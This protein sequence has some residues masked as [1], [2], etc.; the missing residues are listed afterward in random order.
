MHFILLFYFISL[1]P[2]LWH[3]EVPRLGIKSKLQLPAYSI[4]TATPDL[5]CIFNLHHS[6]Q[7]CQILNSPVKSRDWTHVLT[8][9]SR[10]CYYYY[11]GWATV[12]TPI[13]HFNK[14]LLEK[15]YKTQRYK[16]RS[17]RLGAEFE[18]SS[19]TTHIWILASPF[20]KRETS[21]KKL[22]HSKSQFSVL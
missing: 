6:S 19:E 11:C 14:D 16:A 20:I 17:F 1:G 18:F 4:A 10:V 7:Q 15:V 5:S 13:L 21:G 22:T 2:H 12:G 8:D 9:N 3:M